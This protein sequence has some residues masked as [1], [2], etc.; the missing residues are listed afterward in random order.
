[1]AN[2]SWSATV[3]SNAITNIQDVSIRKGRAFLTDAYRSGSLVMTGR[4]PDLLPSIAIGDVIVVTGAFISAPDTSFNF[5]V[6]N[7]EINYGIVSA[8]D[9]W[10][11]TGEDAF[12]YA[13]RAEIDFTASAGANTLLRA[14]AAGTSAGVTVF[15]VVPLS[16]T[17]TTSAQNLTNVNALQVISNLINTEGGVLDANATLIGWYPRNWQTAS[18]P[19]FNFTDDGT[20]VDPVKYDAVNFGA[21]ADTAVTKVIVEPSGLAAQTSGTGNRSYTITTYNQTTADAANVAAFNAGSLNVTAPQP[22]SVSVQLT[23][24]TNKAVM[25]ALN[26]M[27][28]IN[29]KL[30][31]TTYNTLSIGFTLSSTPE[32]TRV[33]FNVIS[34]DFY[35]YLT[36]N[37][38]T[39]GTLDN[40]RLG[41]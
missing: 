38:A 1:M 30:R 4:R 3:N 36:L 17:S 10:T 7:V 25:T 40:N 2:V 31:G 11:I 28:P 23:S 8:M 19:T 5:R 27:T 12:A 16:T 41:F 22:I 24:Q 15:S 26:I 18:G 34:G 39:Y 35:R 13:G 29:I 6:S 9:T 32:N 37:S 20:G 21:L 14:Q 33:T